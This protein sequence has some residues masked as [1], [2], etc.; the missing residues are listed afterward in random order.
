MKYKINGDLVKFFIKVNLCIN[1]RV[2]FCL[3]LSN[4]IE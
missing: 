1:C 3:L 4:F 2:M